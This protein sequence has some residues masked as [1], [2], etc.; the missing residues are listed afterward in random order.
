M[1]RVKRINMVILG[2]LNHEDL[3]GYDIKKRIDSS[4]SFFWN[5]SFGNIYPAL[6]EL[7]N[8]SYILSSNDSVGGR[9]RIVYHIT[10][11]GKMHL[12]EWIS[13][14]QAVNELRY[15]KID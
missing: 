9:E 1:A 11:K 7:E 6:K 12:K 3:T 15:V 10:Q 2:L 14:Q 8:D 5:G 4:I 13:E